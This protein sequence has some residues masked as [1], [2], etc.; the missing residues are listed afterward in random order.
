MVALKSVYELGMQVVLGSA[1]FELPGLKKLKH[2]WYKKHFKT[3][4]IKVGPRVMLLRVH[5]D[6]SKGKLSIGDEVVFCL[7]SYVDYTGG[8]KIGNRVNLSQEVIVFTHNHHVDGISL[9]EDKVSP[10]KGLEICDEVWIGARAIILPSVKRI[11]RGAIVAAGSVLTKDVPDLA[12]F[13]GSPAK[14]IRK[15]K[16]E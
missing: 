6:I 5:P 12:V 2:F 11:G 15:R 13:A 4:R 8:L 3:G 16:L 10:S 7:G 9:F 1:V 14:L